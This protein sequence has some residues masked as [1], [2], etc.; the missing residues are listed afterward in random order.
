MT[1][2]EVETFKRRVIDL[3]QKY[4]HDIVRIEQ[5]YARRKGIPWENIQGTGRDIALEA[6]ART[7]L[8]DPILKELG[9]DISSNSQIV[10]ED[11]VGSPEGYPRFLDYHGRDNCS[12]A[13]LLILEAKRPN[14][15]L[16]EPDRSDIPTFFAEALIYIHT[17]NTGNP[18]RTNL[19]GKWQEF[20]ETL[21]DYANKAKTQFGCVTGKIAISNGEWFVIFND[22]EK[23]LL[24]ESSSISDICVFKSLEDVATRADQFCKLLEYRTLSGCIPPQHPSSLPDFIPQGEI[25]LCAHVMDISYIRHGERQPAISIRVAAWIRIPKGFWV[26]FRK[27]Y[28][29]EFLFIKHQHPQII[30]RSNDLIEGLKAHRA[31]RL[32]S[33]EEFKK[34]SE[35]VEFHDEELSG[36]RSSPLI[37]KIEEDKYRLATGIS[38][39]F[40]SIKTDYPSC[41]FHYWGTCKIDGDA[42]GDAPITAPCSD[43]RAFFPSGD[44]NHCA[45]QTVHNERKNMCLL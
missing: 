14:V 20:I 1:F 17:H 15:A 18:V 16:P 32:V 6:H 33:A 35:E 34:M 38:P 41:P 29:E 22:V 7:Y 3:R 11:A 26:L 27:S 12:N 9:W 19:P 40:I 31:I 42:V 36:R 45:H 39:L 5:D 24:S 25:A 4:D 43:P 10:L 2:A 30:T 28:L 21:I 37:E 23:T 44:P 13:S 8:I